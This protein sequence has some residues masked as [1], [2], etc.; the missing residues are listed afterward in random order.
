M[1]DTN[2]HGK[3][4]QHKSQ[5]LQKILYIVLHCL[6]PCKEAKLY[7]VANAITITARPF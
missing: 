4:C 7:P 1:A 2:F 5:K 6:V 3:S